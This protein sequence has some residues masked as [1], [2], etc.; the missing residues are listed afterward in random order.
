MSRS[1][2]EYNEDIF[3][4]STMTFGEH[5]EDLR[6]CLFKAVLGLA[7]GVFIGLFFGNW[8][9]AVIERPLTE[10]LTRYYQED[11]KIKDLPERQR[12]LVKKGYLYDEVYVDSNDFLAQLKDFYPEVFRDVNPL[13]SKP[14]GKVEVAEQSNTGDEDLMR[15]FLWHSV[16]NDSRLQPRSLGAHE[17]FMIWLKGGLLVG[18]ILAGPWI[19]IQIWS[20]VAAGLY[21][22]EKRYVN[23]YLPFSIGLFF[24]GVA[25]AYF[26]V[27]GPVLNFLF[28]FN[29]WLNI[30]PDLRISEWLGFVL[31]LPVGFGIAF[32]L[33]LVMLFLERIGVFTVKAYLSYWRVAILVIFVVA[34][35]FT[36]PDPWSMSLLAFPLT[37]L[38]FGGILLCKWM[39]RGRSLLPAE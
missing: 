10:A 21:P 32:Q 38:Y 37:L 39:P 36:P 24:L 22:H 14:E 16:K 6:R 15:V 17:P 19:F 23:V 8:V 30:T 7:A 13:P 29:R 12:E 25:V 35:I 3:K 28:K 1:K 31:F 20:F 18:A 33:P 2:Q 11:P 9:V 26:F 34:A 5:L 4:D 27:F